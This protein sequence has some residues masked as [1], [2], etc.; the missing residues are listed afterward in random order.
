MNITIFGYPLSS[1]LKGYFDKEDT[2]VSVKKTIFSDT[3]FKILPFR[4][5]SHLFNCSRSYY[6]YNKCVFCTRFYV[7]EKALSDFL[8]VTLLVHPDFFPDAI[9]KDVLLTTVE[10]LFVHYHDIVHSNKHKDILKNHNKNIRFFYCNYVSNSFML[11]KFYLEILCRIIFNNIDKKVLPKLKSDFDANNSYSCRQVTICDKKICSS[12]KKNK[13][14]YVVMLLCL[15]IVESSKSSTDTSFI[16][17]I[18]EV[19]KKGVDY[20]SQNIDI[21]NNL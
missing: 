17:H 19:H 16:K 5:Y 15:D 8:N 21:D 1:N 4:V 11:Y 12:V 9:T 14:T 3:F 7:K 6:D 13:I 18:F 2:T 10:P 20:S